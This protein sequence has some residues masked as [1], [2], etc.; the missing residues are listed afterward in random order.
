[1]LFRSDWYQIEWRRRA[2]CGPVAATN[3]LC[4]LRKKYG[5]ERI[6]YQN[7]DI[8]EALNAMNDVFLYVRPKR[9]GLH[10]VKKFVK[11]MCRFGR[12]YGVSFRYK[13]M[14]V[15]PQPELRPGLD[16]VARFIVGGLENDVPIAFLNLD[17]G[18]VEDQ[19][20]SWHWVTVV[21]FSRHALTQTIVL[22][23]YDQSRSLE[24]DLGRWLSSTRRGG[25]FAY[26][27][28]PAVR[29]AYSGGALGGV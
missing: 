13:Y 25:G 16:E 29:I 22:R 17:A 15:P 27:C 6:P 21:G 28:K 14:I 7:G 11:G 12:R 26:F 10:T 4:Y 20:Q 24:V 1:V 19:L 3:I 23:Y 8:G 5:F 2:G 18:E 9:R